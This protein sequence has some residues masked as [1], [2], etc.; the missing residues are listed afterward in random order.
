MQR[1]LSTLTPVA[2]LLL[3]AAAPALADRSVKYEVTVTNITPGQTFTPILFATHTDQVDVFEV[4]TQASPELEV[5]AEDGGTGPFEDLLASVP[6]A[7]DDVEVRPG[8][9]APGAS[10]TI[11]IE[12]RRR[13]GIRLSVAAMLIPTNDTFFG[14]DAVSLPRWGSATYYARA[15][16]AGTE[17]NDQDCANMPGPRCGGEGLSAEPAEGDEGFVHVSNGFHELGPGDGASEILGP[18]VYDWRNPVARIV[19]RRLY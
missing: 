14:L 19:V 8:L 17:E 16:D 15:F 10:T 18:Q 2:L 11:T 4:G 13:R 5:L 1:I 3:L 12:R 6:Y 7:V 9:L